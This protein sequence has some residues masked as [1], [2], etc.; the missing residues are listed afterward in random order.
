MKNQIKLAAAGLFVVL[1][2]GAE[3]YQQAPSGGALAVTLL[4]AATTVI[5]F[6]F[7]AVLHERDEA[8]VPPGSVRAQR[9]TLRVGVGPASAFGGVTY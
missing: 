6:T 2:G 3:L 8:S 9:P 1:A 5:G 4:G 7:T